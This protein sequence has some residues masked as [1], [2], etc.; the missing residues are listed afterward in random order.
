MRAQAVVG[1]ALVLAALAGGGGAAR[2]DMTAPAPVP[3]SAPAGSTAED[4]YNRG[5]RAETA[6]DYAGAAAAFRRALELRPA[7][8]EAWNGLG[9]AL[10]SQ[11]NYAGSLAAYDEALR[12]RPDFPEALEYLGEVY[13]ELGRFDDARRVLARLERLDAAR[14]RELAEAIGK[15]R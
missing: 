10:R 9:H 4:E 3:R 11:G 12:L 1:G 15:G 7:Y 2:A 5:L 14:A 13:V 8:P 6:K